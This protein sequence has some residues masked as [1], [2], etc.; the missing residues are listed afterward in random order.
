LIPY[1]I[2]QDMRFYWTTSEN[3]I[4]DSELHALKREFMQ[5][6]G[7]QIERKWSEAA[8]ARSG[9]VDRAGTYCPE[10]ELPAPPRKIHH[11]ETK[12]VHDRTYAR[13]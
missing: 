2:N 1:T 13:R 4:D 12:A 8:T 11:Y 10:V 7:Q 9:N 3:F 6:L 5:A